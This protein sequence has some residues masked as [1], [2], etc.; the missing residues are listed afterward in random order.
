MFFQLFY[1]NTFKTIGIPSVQILQTFYSISSQY[2]SLANQYLDGKLHLFCFLKRPI[3]RNQEGLGLGLNLAKLLS[4]QFSS[5]LSIHWSAFLLILW[6][7]S[8]SRLKAFFSILFNHTLPF[9]LKS[10]FS[11]KKKKFFA[12]YSI[13]KVI[14]AWFWRKANDRFFVVSILAHSHWVEF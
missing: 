2:Q 9:S 4:S 14:L 8:E 13:D 6:S 10:S 1:Q 11:A 7:P 5:G 12:L 3:Y